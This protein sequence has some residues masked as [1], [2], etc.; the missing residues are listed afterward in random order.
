MTMC[1]VSFDVYAENVPCL[2]R[3][4]YADI[5]AV[6]GVLIPTAGEVIIAGDMPSRPGTSLLSTPNI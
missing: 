6:N 5:L 4:M 1:N 3:Y 2:S